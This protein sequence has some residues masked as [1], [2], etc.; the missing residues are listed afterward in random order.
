MPYKTQDFSSGF[1]YLGYFIKPSGYNV[2]DWLWLIKK[3]ENRISHWSYRLLSMGGRLVL[4]RAVL[5][6]PPV[7]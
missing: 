6:S 7:Y 4:I 1:N 2:K 3:F 5:T